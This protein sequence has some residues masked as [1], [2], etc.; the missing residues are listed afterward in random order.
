[1]IDPTWPYAE[2]KR[3]VEEWNYPEDVT[4]AFEKARIELKVLTRVDSK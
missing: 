2:E 1:M 4:C 3:L